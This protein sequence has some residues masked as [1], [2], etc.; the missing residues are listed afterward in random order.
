MRE[1][2]RSAHVPGQERTAE[3]FATAMAALEGAAAPEDVAG[4]AFC[5]GRAA[6]TAVL[7]AFLREGAHVVAPAPGAE[8]LAGV[9]SRFG[10]SAD[11][12]DMADLERV[13]QAVRPS[14]GLL[15][16]ETLAEQV[17]DLRGLYRIARQ[18][19]ALLVVDSTL[20]GPFVC[21]PLEHGADLVL[22]EAAPLLGGHDGC[23]GG[24]VTGRPDLVAKLRRVCADLGVELPPG[25]AGTLRGGL[26][27]LPVRVRRMCST[28]MM[29][30]ASVAKHPRALDVAYPG[31]PEHPGHQLAR[32]LYDCGPEGTRFGFCVGLTPLGDATAFVKSLDLVEEG[33]LGGSRT[34]ARVSGGRVLFSIG[35]EDAEDLLEDVTRALDSLS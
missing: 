4:H 3:G 28:A 8:P 1:N 5:S 11:F 31:L 9:L 33:P 14:T 22:H 20:A 25:E 24:V 34:R 18:A 10:V 21:R 27:T 15:Y 23:A 12:V 7:L 16:A 17:T 19:G 35:L 6:L 29:F 13:R 32:R 2:T 30:A 26:R